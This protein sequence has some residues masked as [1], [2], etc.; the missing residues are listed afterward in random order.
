M[1]LVHRGR[2]RLQLDDARKAGEERAEDAEKQPDI[3]PEDN[4]IEMT[5]DFDAKTQDDDP[6]GQWRGSL[7]A[8]RGGGHSVHCLGGH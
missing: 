3:A 5:D 4:A 2:C 7:G 8:L 1:W 6:A